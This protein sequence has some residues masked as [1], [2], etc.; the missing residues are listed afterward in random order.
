VYQGNLEKDFREFLPSSG[1]DMLDE[2]HFELYPAE[3]ERE[4]LFFEVWIP[5]GKKR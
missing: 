5:L 1:Y 2:I 3:I 4:D